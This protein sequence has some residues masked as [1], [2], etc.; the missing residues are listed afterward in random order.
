MKTEKE[1]GKKER[2]HTQM[3]K[4]RFFPSDVSKIE[5]QSSSIP[6]F[7]PHSLSPSINH[8]LLDSAPGRLWSAT[9]T[10]PDEKEVELRPRIP[11]QLIEPFIVTCG[12][13]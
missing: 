9:A 8:C 4:I 3:R 10:A 7:I 2:T 1:M 5:L 11:P 6:S 12:D 13:H